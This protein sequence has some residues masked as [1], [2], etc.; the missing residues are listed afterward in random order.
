MRSSRSSPPAEERVYDLTVPGLHN[1]V[2]DDLIVHNSSLSL[3]LA[4][5]V[6][7]DLKK[8]AIIFTLEMSKLEVVNRM[9]SAEARI[10]S[11]KLKTGRLD[12]LD[13]RKLGDALGKLSD[14]PPVHRRHPGPHPHG[15]PGQVPPA[16][17]EARPDLVDRRLPRS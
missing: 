10:D 16:Q 7:V 2:A 3:N 12:D 11:N 4:Q 1:F 15:D 8:P 9:L 14:A 17:A 6:T 13:W 5:Y